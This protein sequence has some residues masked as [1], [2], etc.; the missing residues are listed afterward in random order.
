[1]TDPSEPAPRRRAIL[2]LLGI[3]L[4]WGANWPIMKVG[5]GYIPPFWF[6]TARLALGAL[7]LFAL[8]AALGR[9]RLP[10]RADLP[11]LLSVGLLQ[12]TGFL[13]MAN[14]ALLTVAAGRSAVLGY[15]TPLWVTPAAVLLFGE[16]L[17]PLKALG[18]LLGLT[19]LA[20][21][22]NPLHFAWDDRRQLL[23][24][25]AL[26]LG[27]LL[28]SGAILHIRRHRWAASPLDLA[29]WQML[30]ATVILAAVAVPLE[31][32]GWARWSWQLGAVL[33]YNG[34]LATAFCFWASTMVSRDL[35]SITTSLGFLGVPLC[36]VLISALWLGEPLTAS[37]T[38]G[39]AAIL[40]GLAL[41]NLADQRAG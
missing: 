13:A 30:L 6:A 32:F 22:F 10:P 11:V 21:L 35:P 41:V 27:A 1:M 37:L 17:T 7:T 23:G 12:M 19:G 24:N 33:A 28:W 36:G 2:L 34:P 29:P 4:I 5:L 39:L 9:L 16:R 25:G 8:L 31:G 18:L 3:V 38:A 20:V 14:L 40:A 15:T 26:L